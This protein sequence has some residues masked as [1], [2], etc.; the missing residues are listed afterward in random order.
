VRLY[1]HR[2]LSPFAQ[3]AENL[4]RRIRS[5]YTILAFKS[6]RVGALKNSGITGHAARW[7]HA[8][9][10]RGRVPAIFSR[11]FTN[12]I[13]FSIMLAYLS[14]AR[15]GLVSYIACCPLLQNSIIL[16]YERP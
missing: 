14:P 8:A 15:I 4:Q 6:L 11:K 9:Y 7:N 1:I 5:H 3:R 13:T 2:A 16:L 12:L 10:G